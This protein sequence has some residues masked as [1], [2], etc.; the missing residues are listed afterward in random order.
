MR[1][2]GEGFKAVAVLAWCGTVTWFVWLRNGKVPVVSYA[3]FGF[4]ELGHLIGY[5]L[6]LPPLMT[7]AAG[8]FLQV[9]VPL[10]CAAYFLICK[11]SALSSATCL[12][13]ASA[14]FAGA[15]RYI[16]D[17]PSEKFELV[18]G[19]HDWAF[20]FGPE[21]IGNIG[22]ALPTSRLIAALGV[23]SLLAA[24]TMT[25]NAFTNSVRTSNRRTEPVWG[26]A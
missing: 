23:F 9:A 6:F 22:A 20:F 26:R 3:D 5:V 11:H 24:L 25:T 12:A 10:G 17:A 2:V 8:S 13:W 16:A 15:S 7:A 14:N 1:N 18:G 19:E 21:G 4:H